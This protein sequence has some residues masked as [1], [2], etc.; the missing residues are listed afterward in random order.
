[1]SFHSTTILGRFYLPRV[2][3]GSA[4][5]MKNGSGYGHNQPPTWLF[6]RTRP[7]DAKPFPELPVN[8]HRGKRQIIVNPI[9]GVHGMRRKKI[10]LGYPDRKPDPQGIAKSWTSYEHFM[11][12]YFPD[13]EC[14]LVLDTVLNNPTNTPMFLVPPEMSKP[15][16]RSYMSNVYGIR[17]IKFVSTRNYSGMRYKNEFGIIKKAPALKAT[18]VVVDQPVQITHKSVKAAEDEKE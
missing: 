2:N 14:T 17:D 7:P 6:Q 4:H 9:V 16:I 13:V 11:F 5:W 8:T 3:R 18:W 1:M 12:K 15:E 10:E